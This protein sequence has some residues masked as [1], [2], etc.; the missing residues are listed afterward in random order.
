MSPCT[1]ASRCGRTRTIASSTTDA[2]NTCPHGTSMVCT[3]ACARSA[4]S[5][6]RCPNRPNTGTR[7]RSPGRTSDTRAASIPARDVPSTSSVASLVV[8]KTSRYSAIVSFMYP[9]ITGSY[10]PTSGVDRARSTRGSAL[11]GPGPMSRRA[12]GFTGWVM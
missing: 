4:I 8:A 7:T 12:G 10:W 11:T 6:S 5:A 9:V 1:I 2:G 3:S